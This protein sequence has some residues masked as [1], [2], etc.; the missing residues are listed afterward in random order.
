[1]AV[2]TDSDGKPGA[3]NL[4]ST[5]GFGCRVRRRFS[6]PDDRSGLKRLRQLSER[7]EYLEELAG[8]VRRYGDQVPATATATA[9]ATLASLV[10]HQIDQIFD[11]GLHEFLS[12]FITEVGSISTAV[13][14][15]YLSGRM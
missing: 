11:D 2:A 10:A 7:A 4:R 15:D 8:L 12:W 6:E 3:R 1:M 9:H 13:H 5:A 14:D